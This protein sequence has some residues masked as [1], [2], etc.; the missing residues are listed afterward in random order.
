MAELKKMDERNLCGCPRRI[1]HKKTSTIMKNRTTTSAPH[2]AVMKCLLAVM[3]WGP[4]LEVMGPGNDFE[5]LRN[6]PRDG[7]GYM[8]NPLL[9]SDPFYMGLPQAQRLD[10]DAISKYNLA[11]DR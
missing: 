3:T 7:L 1:P 2:P 5:L 11:I 9:L 10:S 4:F 6:D 8:S